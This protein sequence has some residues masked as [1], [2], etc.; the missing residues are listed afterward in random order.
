MT[1]LHYTSDIKTLE[2]EDS[3]VICLSA[4]PLGIDQQGNYLFH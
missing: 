3:R 2:Q 1:Y 4:S